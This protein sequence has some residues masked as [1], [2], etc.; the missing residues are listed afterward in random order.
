MYR[1]AI[2]DDDRITRLELD[3]FIARFADDFQHEIQT[4]LFTDGDELLERSAGS[5]DIIFLDIEM[6]RLN[7]LE[8][9]RQIRLRD[10]QAVI[11]FITS[12]VQYAV[13]GYSVNAMNFLVKPVTYQTFSAELNRA[14]VRIQ[15]LRPTTLCLRTDEGMVPIEADQITYIETVGRKVSIH[16]REHAY[17]CWDTL[18]NLEKELPEIQFFRCHKAYLVNLAFLERILEKNALIAGTEVLVS[19]DRRKDL[20][21]ALVRFASERA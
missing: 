15:R 17:P 18:T 13:Q 11:V 10:D 14:L 2:V 21:R 9:A 7:G 8:T 5:Y 16:T 12:F 3:K 20:M 6:Q 4:A 19:R 1:I